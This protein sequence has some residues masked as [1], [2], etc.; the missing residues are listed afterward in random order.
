M[1][2][3]PTAPA[4]PPHAG[5]L[6]KKKSRN[7]FIIF[8]SFAIEHGV[9]PKGMHQDKISCRV[10]ELWRSL[11]KDH[12]GVFYQLSAQEK[13]RQA[14]YG[15]IYTNEAKGR[16]ARC[17]SQKHSTKTKKTRELPDWPESPKTESPSAS[18][19]YSSPAVSD[20]TPSFQTPFPVFPPSQDEITKGSFE[21]TLGDDGLYPKYFPLPEHSPV[22]NFF[23]PM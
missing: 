14:L 6:A 17:G 8:R 1:S 18:S 11:D 15:P 22:S 4:S 13:T 3:L 12:Q 10:A 5:A 16:K 20:S 23:L 9:V 21:S 2:S 19:S 7:A